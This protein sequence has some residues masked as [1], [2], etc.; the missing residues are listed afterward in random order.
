MKEWVDTW[1]Q[2]CVEGWMEGWVDTWVEEWVDG[3]GWDGMEDE[4]MMDG[5]T[6]G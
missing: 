2:E 3:M 1:V 5:W 4:W 6:G